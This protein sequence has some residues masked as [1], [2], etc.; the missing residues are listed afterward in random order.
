MVQEKRDGLAQRL[1]V[2]VALAIDGLNLL[3]QQVG[4]RQRQRI[5]LGLQ[6]RLQGRQLGRHLC[7][8]FGIGRGEPHRVGDEQKMG[9]TFHVLQ[10]NCFN[11]FHCNFIFKNNIM[12]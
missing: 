5:V 10:F 1:V 12:I 8:Y 2:F 11:L 3:T 9:A 7:F 4:F 6:R